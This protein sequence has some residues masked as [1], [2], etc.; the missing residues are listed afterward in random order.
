MIN[1]TA[2]AYMKRQKLPGYQL[3]KL[4]VQMFTTQRNWRSFL[5]Q[6]GIRKKHHKRIATEGALIGSLIQHGWNTDLAIVGDDA[7]QFNIM[8]HALCWVHAERTI[9]KLFGFTQ[10]HREQIQ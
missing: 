6:H 1:E 7:G 9:Q 5:F 2:I 4:K 10:N 3:Q 8:V